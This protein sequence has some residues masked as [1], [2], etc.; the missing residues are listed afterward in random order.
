LR[1]D[2]TGAQVRLLAHAMNECRET[3]ADVEIA[4][5]EVSEDGVHWR[6][7]DPE[8]DRGQLLHKRI[9]FAPPREVAR[10]R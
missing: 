10:L 7:Y 4:R 2:G 5:H 3:S 1:N 6:P 9:E 8:R